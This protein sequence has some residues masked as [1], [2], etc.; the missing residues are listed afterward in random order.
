M[1]DEVLVRLNHLAVAEV[2]EEDVP[3]RA[4]VEEC[5]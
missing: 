1:H 5:E 3:V 2:L 4:V